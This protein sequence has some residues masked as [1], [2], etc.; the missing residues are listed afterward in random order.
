MD[1]YFP[2]FFLIYSLFL[3]YLYNGL[4][5]YLSAEKKGGTCIEFPLNDNKA[6]L[7]SSRSRLIFDSKIISPSESSV[8]V[9]LPNSI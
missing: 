3:A 9:D 8:S 5:L 7:I 6:F 1:S 2:W 4:P